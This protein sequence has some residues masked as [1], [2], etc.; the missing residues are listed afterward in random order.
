[1]VYADP[2]KS[3]SSKIIFYV[4][5]ALFIVGAIATFSGNMFQTTTH[6]VSDD[7]YSLYDSI[8]SLLQ[9]DVTGFVDGL[10]NGIPIIAMFF[11]LF[12][13]MHFLF[14]TVLKSVFPNPKTATVLS[15]VIAIYGFVDQRIYNMMLSLNS[16][17]IAGLVF[18]ALIIM[19]WGFGRESA[20]NLKEQSRDISKRRD[21]TRKEK[22]QI[23]KY[24]EDK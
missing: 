3:G 6:S 7:V 15:V 12:S 17:A 4:I 20:S 21:L 19:L 24:L 16:F 9:G 23:R 2:E 14:T 22:E 18:G 8:R 10:V 13:I 5:I 11:I 1:M